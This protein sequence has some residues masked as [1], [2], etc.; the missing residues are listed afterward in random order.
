MSGKETMSTAT[1][2][3]RLLPPD[4]LGGSLK[5]WGRLFCLGTVGHS[6]L[7]EEEESPRGRLKPGR[8]LGREKPGRSSTCCAEEKIQEVRG[9]PGGQA[10]P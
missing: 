7:P 8:C 2:G 6:V 1:L 10:L 4:T 9:G 3:L 5:G